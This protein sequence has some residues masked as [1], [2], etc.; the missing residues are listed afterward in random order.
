MLKS[1]RDVIVRTSAWAAAVRFYETVMGFAITSREQDIVGFDTG[2][3]CLYVEKG[4][5]H[6]PVFEFLVVDVAATK[7]RM[8]TA[9][10]TLIEEDPRV[11]RCYVQDPYG[12]RFNIGQ[13]AGPGES[14]LV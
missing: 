12:I 13:S 9:G 8:L 2:A 11:P 7:A 3:F 4:P 6:G 10:C 5:E 14:L 1:T